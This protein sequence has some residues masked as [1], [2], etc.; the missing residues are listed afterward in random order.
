MLEGR[1][2]APARVDVIGRTGDLTW[3][4]IVLREGRSRQIR[5]MADEVGLE[6]QRLV[7]TRIGPQRLG[8]LPAGHW[9][10]LT[11]AELA[12]LGAAAR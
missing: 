6:V 3:L 10:D 7:R 5:R 9:R 11:A 2:T 1:P 4:Q 8:D 12:A